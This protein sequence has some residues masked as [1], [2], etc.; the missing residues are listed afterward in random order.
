[1]D[2]QEDIKYFLG[3]E[4]DTNVVDILDNRELD[5]ETKSSLEALQSKV[6]VTEN[7]IED[8]ELK[9]QANNN[10]NKIK[11]DHNAG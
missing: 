1:M 2:K 5:A 3:K 10:R 4:I 7:W 8:L 9:V 6:K 11:N